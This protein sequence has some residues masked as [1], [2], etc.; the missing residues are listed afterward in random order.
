MKIA[1]FHNLPSGGAKRHTYEQVRE[2]ANR[3]HNITE[4]VPSTA[5]LSFFSLLP[6]I[7]KQYIFHSPN[8]ELINRRIPLFTPYV[9][10]I[11]LYFLLKKT[12]SVNRKIAEQ[13]DADFHDIVL[14]KD[15]WIVSHPYVLKYLKS[16][17][18]FQCH[19]VYPGNDNRNKIDSNADKLK[20][21]KIKEVYYRPAYWLTNK[22]LHHERL[23]NIKN[24]TRVITNSNYSKSKLNEYYG[25]ESSVVY[26]GINTDIFLQNT[27]SKDDFVLTVGSITTQKNHRFL[28][29]VLGLIDK[30][31][32][33]R[34]IIAANIIDQDVKAELLFFA[35]KLGVDLIIT[36][37]FDDKRLVDLY[38]RARVF[39]Y[40]SYQEALGMA[41]LEAMACGTP[42]I[43]LSDGGV[44]ETVVDGVTGWL[45]KRDPNE[46]ADRL[47]LLLSNTELCKTIGSQAASYVREN[48]QW[49]N[50]VDN[51]ETQMNLLL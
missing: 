2:L 26:P 30:E 19:H 46:F 32:R 21:E 48:W 11:Q 12:A 27:N 3:G 5:N 33:P 6:F 34:L 29:S 37:I 43:A 18:I 38:N 51:L 13:I 42:V 25:V 31:K 44:T 17:N 45:V 28:L 20:R 7:D 14:L 22:I 10:F 39:V 1:L 9:H 24:A 8:V 36:Q 41:P 47:E 49:K 23:R 15:C 35:E 4:Y 40:S 50:A 16:R